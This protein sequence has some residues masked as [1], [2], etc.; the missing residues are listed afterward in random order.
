MTN[1]TQNPRRILKSRQI[2]HLVVVNI[3][4]T[5]KTTRWRRL[6]FLLLGH[7]VGSYAAAGVLVV[8]AKELD[9]F[10]PPSFW[11]LLRAAPVAVPLFVCQYIFGLDRPKLLA[12]VVIVVGYGVAF[13]VF[14]KLSRRFRLPQSCLE[15]GRGFEVEVKGMVNGE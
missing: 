13:F 11:V 14:W 7:L 2:S 6:L 4:R 5:M 3:W 1:R 8:V 15:R 12:V 9:H 10:V